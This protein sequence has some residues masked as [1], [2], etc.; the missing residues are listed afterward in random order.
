[1]RKS[2]IS[3]T[4]LCI[5]MVFMVACSGENLNNGE[6]T[7]NGLLGSFNPVQCEIEH[8]A[9]AYMMIEGI[10]QGLIE[11]DAVGFDNGQLHQVFEYSHH[12]DVPIDPLTN[13]PVGRT[14]QRPLTVTIALNHS[15]PK[16]YQMVSTGEFGTVE[17]YFY[18]YDSHC[19]KHHYFTVSLE[20]AYFVDVFMTKESVFSGDVHAYPELLT[21]TIGFDKITW[22]DVE[23]EN[24]YSDSGRSQK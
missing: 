1:M 14:I 5:L 18:Q 24:T 6:Y 17:I 9:M 3:I 13:M 10:A 22:F 23:S 15:A 16:L 8:D 12:T 19:V 4:M 20:N 11:G 7:H 21:L 2:V